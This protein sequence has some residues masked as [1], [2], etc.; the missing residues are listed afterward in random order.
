MKKNPSQLGFTLLEVIIA[1]T[2]LA[3]L[4]LFT[5]QV[6]Q[7]A[8]RNKK[9]IS[10]DMNKNTV[11][12]DTLKVISR[13]ISMAF[14]HRDLNIE[15]YNKAGK[16]RE[17]NAKKT[18]DA[19]KVDKNKD[20]DGDGVKDSEE[21]ENKQKLEA[22]ENATKEPFKPK[23]EVILT[24]FIGEKDKLNFTTLSYNRRFRN[25]K[26][27]RQAEVG[28][29]LKTCRQRIDKDKS[30]NCLWRRTSPFIDDKVDEGGTASVLVENVKKFELRYLGFEKEAEYRD[31]WITTEDG[32]PNLRNTFPFAVEVT[33]VLQDKKNSKDKEIGMTILAPI[34]FPNNR[35]QEEAQGGDTNA[36]NGQT[37]ATQDTQSGSQ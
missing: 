33:L 3:F 2:I 28:Y 37:P 31:T 24:H 27:S 4:S 5:T 32:D 26:A 35:K 16:K 25:E 34:R 20:S 30:S 11:L 13:D 14:N 9:K 19:A 22:A 7:R 29:F 17:E 6:I 15:V 36:E 23:T 18:K 21:E 1:I 12:R 10:T 8:V